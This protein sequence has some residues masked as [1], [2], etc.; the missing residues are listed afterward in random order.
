MRE[1]KL[2]RRLGDGDRARAHM[3]FE[4]E[5]DVDP[6]PAQERRRPAQFAAEGAAV[7]WPFFGFGGPLAGK[8]GQDFEEERGGPCPFVVVAHQFAHRDRDRVASS[9]LS[10]APRMLAL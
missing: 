4:A 5:V 10:T 2:S 8:V 3:A 6:N 7:H 1:L 9:T